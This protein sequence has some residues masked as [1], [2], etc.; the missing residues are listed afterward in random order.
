MNFSYGWQRDLPDIR[1]LSDDNEKVANVLKN[2]SLKL[3]NSVDLRRWCS[4]IEDQK[5][6]GS[7]TSNSGVGLL[8][9]F[10]K[11]AFGK[12][13]HASRLFLYKTTR[14]LMRVTGDTGATMRLTMK[15]MVLFG[16]PPEE[17]LPYDITK[18]DIE[19]SAF[20]YAF[21]D[22]YKSIVYYKLDPAGTTPTQTLQNVK[23]KLMMGLPSMFGFTVYSSLNNSAFI[24]FPTAKDTVKGGHAIVAVGFSDDMKIGNCTG[25][26]LIRNS[27]GTGWGD[28]GFGWL[29]Y[30]YVLSGLAVDFW[31][32]VKSEYVDSDLFN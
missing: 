15:A 22:N 10:E 26:L 16:I 25:A 27:W 17:Y 20:H 8:E 5:N 28:K 32:L 13:T 6:L 9:Y 31:S 12:F 2:G 4:P 1:D 23:D 7:C 14:N 11:K 18:F 30:Q 19:P 29:P 24:P 21:A 3:T